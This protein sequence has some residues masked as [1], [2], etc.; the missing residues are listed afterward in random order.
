M[1][2]YGNEILKIKEVLNEKTIF[3][4]PK[5]SITVNPDQTKTISFIDD[6][7]F[8][9]YN[10]ESFNSATKIARISLKD[11]HYIYHKNN[12]NKKQWILNSA[13]RKILINT[14]TTIVGTKTVYDLLLDDICRYCGVKPNIPLPDFSFIKE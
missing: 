6:P 5:I 10:G 3:S 9:I 2:I 4:S 7:Y 8:K 12:R 13:E 1:G 14:L 11:P